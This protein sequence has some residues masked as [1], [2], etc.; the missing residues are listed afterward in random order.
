MGWEGGEGGKFIPLIFFF[1][2]RDPITNSSPVNAIYLGTN[3]LNSQ[4]VAIKF[5][6]QYRL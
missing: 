3:L 2:I 5:V 4:T 6:R 1:S